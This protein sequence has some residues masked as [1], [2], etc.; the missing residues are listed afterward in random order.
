[1]KTNKKYSLQAANDDPYASNNDDFQIK[2]LNILTA[3]G[4]EKE[5]LDQQFVL[6]NQLKRNTKTLSKA[7]R[8]VTFN[9]STSTL[10]SSF[11]TQNYKET[12]STVSSIS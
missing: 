11:S 7:V 10:Y 3:I 2:N 1:M 4:K 12:N 5:I 8:D 6:L 9:A